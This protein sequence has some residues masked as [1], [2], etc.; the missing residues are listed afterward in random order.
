MSTERQGRGGYGNAQ[1]V[2][3]LL[4]AIAENHL[5]LALALS[6]DRPPIS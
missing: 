4:S 2:Y 1:T 6:S 5:A 3:R